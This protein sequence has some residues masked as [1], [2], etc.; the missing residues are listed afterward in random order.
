MIKI[1]RKGKLKKEC[2]ICHCRFSYE[3]EEV[4]EIIYFSEV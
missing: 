4:K 3:T 2:P 1:I